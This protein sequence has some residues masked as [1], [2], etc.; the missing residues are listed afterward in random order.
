MA[1]TGKRAEILA[2]LR[3]YIAEHG[4]GPS[5][6]EICAATGLRSTGSAHYQL[7]ALARDGE[8]LF[9]ENRKRSISLP[10]RP[11]RGQVPVVGVVT[12]GEPILAVENVEGYLPWDGGEG[13][14]ALRVRGESM[15]NAGILPGDKV[16][17][18]PQS[19]ADSGDIVV[20]LLGDEATVKRLSLQDGAVWLLPENEAFDPIDGADAVILGKVKG[21]VREYE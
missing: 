8:I 9:D 19:S 15:K 2:Y 13:M 12:A 7:K 6:R 5:V 21:V 10:V 20:A 17:V 18:R 4:Y 1:R 11:Q 3:E 14:F 16:V